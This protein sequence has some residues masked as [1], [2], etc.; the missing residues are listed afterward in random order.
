MTKKKHDRS[1]L[2]HS[3]TIS[4]Q[5]YYNSHNV[6]PNFFG[7]WSGKQPHKSWVVHKWFLLI[8][9]NSE[10]QSAISK[11]LKNKSKFVTKST[12]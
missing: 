4:K 7:R 9:A 3:N 8:T 12:R 2:L 10:E 6:H 1:Q 5:Y 11:K